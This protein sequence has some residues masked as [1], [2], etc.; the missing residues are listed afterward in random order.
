VK[1]DLTDASLEEEFVWF[2]ALL[3]ECGLPAHVLLGNHDVRAP[4]VDGAGVLRAC[5]VDVATEATA[6]DVPGLRIV[7][8]PSARG[9]H[10]AEWKPADRERVVTFAR[11]SAAPLFVATHHYPQRLNRPNTLPVG[12]KR[13]EA[14]PLLDELDRIA[15]GSIVAA[16]H[17]H[18]HHRRH[19]RSLL[20]TEIGSP[21]DYPGVWAG[22]VVYEGGIVQT[23][24]QV[25]DPSCR[26]WIDRTGNVLGGLWR[27]WSPGI[28]SHR[29]WTWVWPERA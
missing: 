1:G 16:G 14:K 8:M 17:T 3:N 24:R 22:Y 6:V 13:R 5:G 18:R 23:V 4:D 10:D 12:V 21:K 29:C 28:R 9:P 27:R 20:L 26:A 25:Q 2:A 7:M 11:E 19:Y 15:P